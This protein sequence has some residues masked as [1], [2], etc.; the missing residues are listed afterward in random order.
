MGNITYITTPAHAFLRYL[1][2]CTLFLQLQ[3]A[4]EAYMSKH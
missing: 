3:N 4:R 1:W 2:L